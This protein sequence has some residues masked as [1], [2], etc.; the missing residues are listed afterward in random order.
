MRLEPSDFEKLCAIIKEICGAHIRRQKRYLLENRIEPLLLKYELKDASELLPLV[1]DRRN[2]R[3]IDDVIN[4][5][6][7]HETSFFRN[8]QVFDCLQTYIFPDI[9]KR[10]ERA[11]PEVE[12]SFVPK[13]RIWSCAS[14]T[15]QEPYSLAISVLKYCS[16]VNNCSPSEFAILA[17]DI[18]PEV[19]QVAESGEYADYELS[20]GISES[21]RDMWFKKHGRFWKINGEA[22]ALVDFRR[23][24]LIAPFRGIASCDIIFCRNV[25]IYFDHDTKAKIVDRLYDRLK[26]YGYLILGSTENLFHVTDRFKTVRFGNNVFYQKIP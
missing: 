21:D 23:I 5:I 18:S 14:S 20:R 17:S 6:T 22:K 3:L 13:C 4:S 16:L 26:N 11:V 25:L 15:G 19:L 9:C 8:S 24:N 12:L 1:S 7:T 2:T 10:Y